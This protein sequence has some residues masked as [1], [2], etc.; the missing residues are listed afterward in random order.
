MRISAPKASEGVADIRFDEESMS[1][2]LADGRMI[3]VP[4]SGW[5]GMRDK[6]GSERKVS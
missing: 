1:V 2:D 5:A 3:T 4:P 6:V